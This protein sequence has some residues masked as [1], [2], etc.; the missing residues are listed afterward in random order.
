MIV[1]HSSIPPLIKRLQRPETRNL[2]A[3]AARFLSLIAKECA[4]MFKNHVA[5]LLIV[6]ADKSNDKLAEVALQ[7]LAAVCKA[8][9]ACCPD[10]RRPVDRAIK[11]VMQGTPR[12]AKFA[13]RF[14]AYCKHKDASSEL[15]EVRR[16]HYISPL[17]D[18]AASRF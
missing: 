18:T 15:I 13:A 2:A 1:N 14:L 12:Q 5:E 10:D 7:A 9:P 3:V 11:M 17:A 4:P 8:D 6:M 16:L